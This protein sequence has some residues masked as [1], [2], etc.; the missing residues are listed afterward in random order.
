MAADRNRSEPIER[1][2]LAAVGELHEERRDDGV[3]VG[4]GGG[5]RRDAGRRRRSAAV[6]LAQL[7]E[8]QQHVLVEFDASLWGP[9]H[10]KKNDH[11]FFT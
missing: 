4:G 3:G 1:H 7:R 8:L 10:K 2:L 9:V 6:L 11:F 5:R